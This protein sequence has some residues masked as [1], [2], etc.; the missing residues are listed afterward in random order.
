MKPIM[1]K[2]I[3]IPKPKRPRLYVMVEPATGAHWRTSLAYPNR[4]GLAP[5]KAGAFLCKIPGADDEWTED[6]VRE[7]AGK[8]Y[9]EVGRDCGLDGYTEWLTKFAR[10]LGVLAS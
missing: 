10:V 9:R 6:R 2:I 5:R 4:K 8:F 7:A 3:D 1:A